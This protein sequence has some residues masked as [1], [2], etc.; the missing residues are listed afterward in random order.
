MKNDLFDPMSSEFQQDRYAVFKEMRTHHPIYKEPE[1]EFGGRSFTRW[2]FMAYEDVLLMF[3]DKRFITDLNKI[4][5]SEQL[6]PVPE[7]V[8]AL[9]ESQ[10]NMMLYRDPPDHTR[11]RSTINKAFTPRI[12]ER[13]EPRIREISSHLLKEFEP[14]ASF[15]LMRNFSFPL[16]AIVNAELLGAPAEDRDLIKKWSE[17]LTRTADYKPSKETLMHGNQAII[18]FRGYCRDL[19]HERSRNPK[20]DLLSGLIRATHDG[21]RMSEDELLDMC[22]LIL[23]AGY[24]T[25]INLI[26]NA[27]YLMIRYTKQQQLLRAQ[28]KW[29]ESA[30]EEVLRFEPPSQLRHRT[31]GE[32]ME[33][34]GYMLRRGDLVSGWIASANRDP[35][36][37]IDSDKFDITRDKNPHL[38]F[39][40]GI[41]F[42]LGAPLARKEGAIA[43][44]T[45]LDKFMCLNL[46]DEQPSWESLPGK[47]FLKELI[48]RV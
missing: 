35:D 20:N 7:E 9:D 1:T 45:L 48:V 4:V 13:L 26:T 6:P 14:G 17:L 12:I 47:R 42:C 36:V 38:S 29:M 18:E 3:R 37:F 27:V 19:V 21:R 16:P 15:D 39:G 5:S 28:P 41:H 11:L 24:E 31:V 33:Y 10:R 34:K 8:Q 23:E 32:D 22:V 46:V 2:H 30:I 25:T 44:K 43:L 40:Q